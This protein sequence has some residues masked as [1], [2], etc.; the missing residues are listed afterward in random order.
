MEAEQLKACTGCLQS[1]PVSEFGLRRKGRATL[2]ARC[3]RCQVAEA[4][5][6]RTGN[7]EVA[8]A[9]RERYAAA[10]RERLSASQRSYDLRRYYGISAEYVAEMLE[11]QGGACAICRTDKP[12]GRWG[13]FAVDH[14]HASGV[15]R[16]LLCSRCNVALGQFDDDTRKLEAAI[17]YLNKAKE[18]Q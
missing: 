5:L 1:K 10:N 15:V 4:T 8:K 14:C 17:G 12:G 13:K 3:K 16:G 2:R 9:G 7:P 6:W 11:K 18:A